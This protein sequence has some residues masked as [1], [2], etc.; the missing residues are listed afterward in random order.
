[1]RRNVAPD[2]AA[3][4]P[5]HRRGAEGGAEIAP[6]AA[7]APRAAGGRARA[8]LAVSV[9]AAEA[10]KSAPGPGGQAGAGYPC[11]GGGPAS[12]KRGV[13]GGAKTGHLLLR[14]LATLWVRLLRRHVLPFLHAP[15]CGPCRLAFAP[16]PPQPLLN[17]SG[18]VWF[19]SPCPGF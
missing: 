9:R 14:R 16:A 13:S 2:A 8:A 17:L 15:A 10:P 7:V 1:M 12:C 4:G 11:L 6:R 18:L 19:P 3:W 5:V